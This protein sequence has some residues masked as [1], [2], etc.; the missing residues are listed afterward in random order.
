MD[1]MAIAPRPL[2]RHA[3]LQSY[4]RDHHFGLLLAWKL[5][6][7]CSKGISMKRLQ[8]YLQCCWQA[9][10]LPHFSDEEQFLLTHLPT[11]DAYANRTLQ[12]HAALANLAQSWH[13]KPATQ[14]DLLRFADLLDAHIRFEERGLFGYLQTQLDAATLQQLESIERTARK[15]VDS[16]WPDLF[17][18]D[19]STSKK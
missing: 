2:K 9:E 18:L 7:G 12:E 10:L 15:D 17:W 3:A 19:N 13:K 8:D 16:Q 4:S 6:K 11:G 1:P 5:R 14:E